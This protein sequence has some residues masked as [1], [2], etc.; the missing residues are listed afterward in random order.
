MPVEYRKGADCLLALSGVF[1][2]TDMK[3][4]SRVLIA[5][6]ACAACR[7]EQKNS[8]PPPEAAS[9]SLSTSVNPPDSTSSPGL[10][11]AAVASAVNGDML[12]REQPDSNAYTWK[13][14]SMNNGNERFTGQAVRHPSGVL[15]L[16]FD[17]T[18]RA[19]EDTPARTVHV[20]SLVVSGLQRGEYVTPYC[21]A[22]GRAETWKTQIVGILRDTTNYL[23]PRMSWMLDTMSHRIRAIPTDPV[24]CS[25]ADLFGDGGDS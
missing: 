1:M 8:E 17:T 12:S 16:W 7:G 18:T 21:N 2:V 4:I 11:S 15:V 20:D 10:P 25:A 14:P 9:S 13:F 3:P 5:M 24:L 19:T 22:D 6:L 23:R